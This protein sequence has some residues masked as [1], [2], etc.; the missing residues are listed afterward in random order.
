MSA[1]GDGRAPPPG[2]LDY[3]W[4]RR[5]VLIGVLVAVVSLLVLVV[6]RGSTD[7]SGSHAGPPGDGTGTSAG[8]PGSDSGAP[9]SDSGA[10]GSDS[11][12]P[13]GPA[14]PGVPT[15]GLPPESLPGESVEEYR[16]RAEAENLRRQARD[17][18]Q[19]LL[20]S[21]DPAT[22]P[23]LHIQLERVA[24]LL[25]HEAQADALRQEARASDLGGSDP[26]G[27]SGT[28]DASSAGGVTAAVALVGALA[29][30]LTAVAGLLTALVAWRK[31]APGR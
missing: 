11:G 5:L 23:V 22:D 3:R 12:A 15:M 24:D 16:W 26:A 17:A 21:R 1:Q 4:A 20:R 25:E 13:G 14:A 30:M 10:P 29:G 6:A 2:S 19:S 31:A 27:T 7:D 18:L 28:P 8:P 9:G